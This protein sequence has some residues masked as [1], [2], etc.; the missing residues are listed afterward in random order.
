MYKRILVTL[1][2][3]AASEAILP[4]VESMAGRDEPQVFLLTVAEVPKAT[5]EA[6]HPLIV[7]GAVA[8]GGVV[9][10]PPPRTIEDK[11]QALERTKQE[12]SDYLEGKAAV[13]RK[14]GLHVQ[15]EVGFG[16]PAEEILT[17]AKAREADLIMMATHGRTGLAQV[18]FG[19]VAARVVGSGVRP[20]LLVRP[21]RLEGSPS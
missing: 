10:V 3:S 12:L 7:G 6:P 20:V 13:L 16:D 4:Q 5:A 21:G 8:P 2:R 1:D 11:G 9:E 15:P 17:A 18:I 14:R 19:S